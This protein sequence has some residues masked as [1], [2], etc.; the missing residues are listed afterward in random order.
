MK[1]K[2]IIKSAAALCMGI[3]VGYSVISGIFYDKLTRVEPGYRMDSKNTPTR[4]APSDPQYA[5]IDSH[6]YFMPNFTQVS[7]PGYAQKPNFKL[8]GWYIPHPKSPSTAIIVVHGLRTSKASV[9]ALIPAGMLYKNGFSVLVI[10]LRNHGHSD[11]DK[12]RTSIGKQEATDIIAAQEWLTQKGYTHIGVYGLSLG[13]TSSL[14]AFAKDQKLDAAFLD[15]GFSDIHSI[16]VSE[17][18]LAKA[19]RWVIPG[20]LF[21]AKCLG[22]DILKIDPLGAATSIQNRPLLIAHNQKDN[23][24]PIQ[25]AT[26][27]RQAL[28]NN[29]NAEFWFYITSEHANAMMVI[30][31]EYE[32]KLTTFFRQNLN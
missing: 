14:F 22:L 30:P 20:G 9:T 7:F 32:Q 2:W 28:K 26:K 12:G 8:S 10:D 17:V 21:I 1:S 31:N 4:W 24:I 27:L 15:S 25:H 5:H 23:R 18:D 16:I 13:A 29:P 11:S 6:R 19:P 3:G